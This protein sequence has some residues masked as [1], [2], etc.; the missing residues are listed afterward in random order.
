MLKE[1]HDMSADEGQEEYEEVQADLRR[2][3]EEAEKDP[4]LGGSVGIGASNMW[5]TPGETTTML[6]FA[7][8]SFD[9]A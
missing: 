7:S 1:G 8:K 9:L 4:E 2:R 3:E 5:V 6:D